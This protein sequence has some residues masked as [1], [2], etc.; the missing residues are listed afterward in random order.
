MYCGGITQS[1]ST[2]T[3]VFA[4]GAFHT[5]IAGYRAALVR[6][7]EI[8]GRMPSAQL[9]RQCRRRTPGEP[10]STTIS[11]EV[12]ACLL[13]QAA[14]EVGNFVAPVVYR[15]NNRKNAVRWP[16]FGLAHAVFVIVVA[17]TA[18]IYTFAVVTGED[19]VGVRR[20]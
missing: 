7:E 11:S 1:L 10:S 8:T 9:P 3:K 2:K 12:G 5:V 4:L 6:L 18:Q 17:E 15:Y 14:A 20:R 19:D 16:W 13:A